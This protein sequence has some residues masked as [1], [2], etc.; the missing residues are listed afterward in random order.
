MPLCFDC[1]YKVYT[2]NSKLFLFSLHKVTFTAVLSCFQ[3]LTLLVKWWFVCVHC[4]IK[5]RPILGVWMQRSNS[6]TISCRSSHSSCSGCSDLGGA[7]EKLRAPSVCLVTNESSNSDLLVHNCC[8]V[9]PTA[10]A[11][12]SSDSSWSRTLYIDG[13]HLWSRLPPM[14]HLAHFHSLTLFLSGKPQVSA[15]DLLMELWD[16]ARCKDV[17]SVSRLAL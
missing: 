2:K 6:V 16:V 3:T 14:A 13:T 9:T 12:G 4:V 5:G 11:V 8:E 17:F 15:D 1:Y 7:E 10:A